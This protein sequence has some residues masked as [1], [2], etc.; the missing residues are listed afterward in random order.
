MQRNVCRGEKIKTRIVIPGHDFALASK[1]WYSKP[2]S[3]DYRIQFTGCLY[4]GTEL[5]KSE[6]RLQQAVASLSPVRALTQH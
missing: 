2:N 5:L 6:F 1:N 4:I 3:F